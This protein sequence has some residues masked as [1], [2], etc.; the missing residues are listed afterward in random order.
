MAGQRYPKWL[1]DFKT[2]CEHKDVTKNDQN[3]AIL[4][5]MV[6][7]FNHEVEIGNA[8]RDA[9][10]SDGHIVRTVTD[11]QRQHQEFIGRMVA[12]GYTAL[13]RFEDRLSQL[14][15]YIRA[16]WYRRLRRFRPRPVMGA[17]PQDVIWGPPAELPA[18]AAPSHGPVDAVAEPVAA[19]AGAVDAVDA[20]DRD[21]PT[22]PD[23]PSSES[24]A[25]RPELSVVPPLD[26][27]GA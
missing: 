17:A 10:K 12:G 23:A 16:P 5:L 26:E 3:E 8:R 11:A 25:E 9:A 4:D 14:E 7:S 27:K 18:A 15:D 20:V 22:T 2:K 13:G 1:M 6:S 24:P 19:V 21:A